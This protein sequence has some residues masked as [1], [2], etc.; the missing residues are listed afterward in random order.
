MNR[1]IRKERE[2]DREAM[3]A[4]LVCRTF[5]DRAVVFVQTKKQA[6]RLHVALGLLGIKV[7][8]KILVF[9]KSKLKKSY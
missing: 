2:S 8:L 9:S 6:H 5:R 4:A 7:F 1:R 3:L